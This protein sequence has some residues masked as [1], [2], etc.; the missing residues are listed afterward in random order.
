MRIKKMMCC[1]SVLMLVSASAITGQA[2]DKQTDKSSDGNQAKTQSQVDVK[3]PIVI[4]ADKLSFSDL[5]GDLFADGN[6][7]IVQN[8]DK[9]LTDSMRGNSKQTEFWIDGKANFSQT[10]TKLT[11]TGTHY[12]YGQHSGSM[13]DVVGI[14]DKEHVSGKNI[15]MLPA[16]MIIHDGTV[17]T[18]PAIVPDYHVSAE[19]IEIWPGDKMIVYNAKFWIRNVVIF[20][21]P[22]YQTSLQ[23]DAAGLQEAFPRIGY[24]SDDGLSIKQHLEEPI[25]GH[26]AVYTDLWFYSKAGFKPQI[27]VIDREKAYSLQLVEG[28]YQDSNSNW[29]T[30]KPELDF[31][32]YSHRLGKLPVSYTFSAIYG[33]WTDSTKTSWHQDYN[34]YF[35]HDTISLSKSLSLNL[36]T[37]IEQVRESFDGSIRNTSKFDTTLTKQWS[38]RFTTLAEYHYTNNNNALFS[39]DTPDLAREADLGFK[40]TMDQKNAIGFRQSYD[41]N[42][43]KIYDQDY[44]WYK[45]LHCW[46]AAITYRAKRQQIKFDLSTT[47]F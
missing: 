45:D 19:K 34:L 12:N 35:S 25:G 43:S 20:S 14:V 15:D 24:T 42:T 4:E 8:G 32:L 31:N 27:G 33:Q 18:C 30:K 22:K 44:T 47:H 41:L 28:D 6:V 21:L 40:Y 11:G 13:Q 38:P 7:S 2:A 23:K 10:G 37:G 29:I 5:T 46:Q 9:I 16:E 1:A 39:Y 3:L 26:V 17:T 36:G